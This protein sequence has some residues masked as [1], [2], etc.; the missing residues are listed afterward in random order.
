MGLAS[1]FPL[2]VQYLAFVPAFVY[3]VFY[4]T[5]PKKHPWTLRLIPF[6]NAQIAVSHWLT[7][8]QFELVRSAL[9]AT[10]QGQSPELSKTDEESFQDSQW[11]EHVIFPLT[12]PFKFCL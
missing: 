1:E 2:K 10:I 12:L 8:W 4:K 11:T 3:K 5:E 9:H 7:S 6:W